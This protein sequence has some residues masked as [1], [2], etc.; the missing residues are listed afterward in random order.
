MTSKHILSLGDLQTEYEKAQRTL[1]A[2]ASR[3]RSAQSAYLT[4]EK[5][6]AEARTAL[7]LGYQVVIHE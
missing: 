1:D 3:L 7:R 5:H 2:C 4:A 6:L